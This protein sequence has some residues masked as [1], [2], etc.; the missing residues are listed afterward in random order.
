MLLDS[1]D[2]FAKKNDRDEIYTD[3]LLKVYNTLHYDA[4]NLGKREF[5][6]GL[7]Y[8]KSEEAKALYPF[9]S[10]NLV[11]KTSRKPVFKPY[12]IRTF[13]EKSTLG[14]KHG[15]VKIGIF[16]VASPDAD[17]SM[18]IDEKNSTE[19]LDPISTAEQV[20]AELSRTCDLIIGMG[21]MQM[22]ESRKLVTQ[23]KG[24]HLFVVSGNMR[25]LY[26]PEVV[27]DT[28]TIL[29]KP[30]YR[31]K[32]VGEMSLKFDVAAKQVKE[33]SGKLVSIDEKQPLDSEINNMVQAAKKSAMAVN[34]QETSAM[35][36]GKKGANIGKAPEFRAKYVG[37]A[38]CAKCHKD[39]V[40][41]WE[42]TKHAHAFATLT[43]MGKQDDPSCFRCHTTGY[44]VSGG[45]FD[46]KDTPHLI[47]VR[48]EACHGAASMHIDNSKIRLPKPN[49]AT[50][51][52]C[53]TTA[54]SRP[55]VWARDKKLV[56]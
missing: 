31:G 42:K 40:D 29:V 43:K 9:L 48:C 23:V 22:E 19:L 8:L 16:G 41:R 54:R 2:A 45:Y 14:I 36:P 52:E 56:H 7:D 32:S 39:I 38:G 13:G 6:Y 5:T 37:S 30:A 28:G 20:V 24:I 3:V 21:N 17:R 25:R 34:R 27:E 46:Q 35:P 47:D 33:H 10:A 4:L 18:S 51:L 49:L 44:T 50:C 15:G 55:L 1:G 26:K 53:H 11:D 12:V